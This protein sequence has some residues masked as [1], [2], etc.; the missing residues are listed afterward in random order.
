M[1][2]Y[3]DLVQAIQD[4][5]KEI[6]ITDDIEMEAELVTLNDTIIH[7]D[8]H[9]L[10]LAESNTTQRMFDAGSHTLTLENL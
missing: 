1:K 2:N 4:G 3:G 10:T 7:G 6:F 9:T 5:Q 8:G